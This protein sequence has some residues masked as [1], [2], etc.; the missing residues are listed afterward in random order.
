[1]RM[2]DED[3]PQEWM[4]VLTGLKEIWKQNSVNGPTDRAATVA[5][6]IKGDSLTAFDSALEDARVDPD[7]NNQAPVV[8]T[9]EH[10]ETTLKAVTE[11]V[12]PFRALETQKQW[13]TRSMKK[14]YDLSSRKTAA[15]L[16]RINNY[17]P[18]F[19]NGVAT[20][21]YSDSE[22]VGLFEWSLPNH[23]RKT[24]DKKGFVPSMHTIKELIDECERI[25][26]NEAPVEKRSHE[27]NNNN[28]KN[29]KKVKFG[30]SAKNDKKSDR[31]SG[32]AEN[33]QTERSFHCTKCGDNNTHNTDRCYILKNI[34]RKEGGS[35]K[36]K[37]FSKRTFRKEINAIARRAGKHAGLD[38][39]A[40]ALK[41]EELKQEK[42]ARRA[43]AALKAKKA[44]AVESE[45]SDSESD[46]SIHK[47]DLDAPIPRKKAPK[48]VAKSPS[49]SQKFKRIIEV[50]DSSSD[51]DESMDNNPTKEEK[52]FLKS[53]DKEEAE[54]ASSD[55]SN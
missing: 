23:W 51:E 2:F 53:I 27:D 11:V 18:S 54:T 29:N 33:G 10:I 20:S 13:M 38:L 1:M 37:P 28:N 7:P 25:E 43:K 19:P 22:L 41:R 9:I 44:K 3:T 16:S 21:K 55:E 45:E 49:T 26:R 6:I 17:L 39:F 12:F 47:M 24:M 42:R 8:M 48:Q 30:K 40:S 50:D 14:P 36:D 4:E 46:E 34:A 52:A 35:T 15:A 31:N 5:A 32:G